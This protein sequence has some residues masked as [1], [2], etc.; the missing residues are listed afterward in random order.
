MGQEVAGESHYTNVLRKVARSLGGGAEGEGVTVAHLLPDPTNKY[1]SNAVNVLIGGQQVG[2]L[3]ARDAALYSPV[4]RPLADSGQVLQVPARVWWGAGWEG[5]FMASVTLDL[6]AANLL[7]P[8]NGPPP[9]VSLAM[10]TGSRLQLTGEDQHMDVLGPIMASH[11]VALLNVTLHEIT[12]ER[13]RSSKQFVEARFNGRAIGL[14]SAAASNT[15]LPVIRR[16]DELGVTLY[17]LAEAT[18]NRLT[19][20]VV[21]WTAKGNALDI[22]W[23]DELEGLSA[24]SSARSTTPASETVA[25]AGSSS[26]PQT[27]PRDVP[28]GWYPDPW[29]AT[30]LRYWDGTQWT[31]HTHRS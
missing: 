16:A 10:P 31:G 2:N 27:A 15:L 17:A 19:T 5:D 21:V 18:G 26:P 24:D 14:L 30:S 25:A 12:V 1:D 13:P 22:E 3:P 6:P 28:A 7:F 8:V 20:E 11:T 23:L 29:D 4:L 9:G